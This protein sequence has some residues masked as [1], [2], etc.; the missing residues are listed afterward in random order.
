MILFL[1]NDGGPKDDQESGF[2]PE[3]MLTSCFTLHLV[4]VLYHVFM[5]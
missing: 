5:F 1:E 2:F 3:T 4:Y